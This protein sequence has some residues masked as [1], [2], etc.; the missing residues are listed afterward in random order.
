M[1]R[2]Y[3]RWFSPA[4]GRDMELL[5]FGH[6]GARL[7]VFPTSQG[8]FYEF[9]DRSITWELR[10]YLDNGWIQMFCVDS[11]DGDSWY[12]DWKHPGARAWRQ[13][14]YD[15]YLRDELVPFS[16]WRNPNPF[17]ITL[18]TSFGAYHAVNFAFRHPEMVGRVLGFHGLYDIRR[19]A[20]GYQDDNVYYNNPM[21][22]IAN[23]HEWHR[24]DAFRRLD[25]ILVTDAHDQLAWS[26][27]HFSDMLWS[28]GIHHTKR[29]WN[30]WSHDWPFWKRMLHLYLGGPD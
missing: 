18:G 22:F 12:A 26:T 27:H 1:N 29:V 9:E 15:R 6:A 30:E 10:H 17:L 7:L 28:K 5:V 14:Q 8:R 13:E 24:M 25:V 4:L 19:F 2:E 21:Q 3:H 23:E 11:V 20:A 16:R